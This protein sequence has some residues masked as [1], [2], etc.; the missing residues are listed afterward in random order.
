[1]AAPTMGALVTSTAG[2][3][4]ISTLFPACIAKGDLV[5]RFIAT[6]NTTFMG[7]IGGSAAGH[8]MGHLGKD[9]AAGGDGWFALSVYDCTE[10]CNLVSN[11]RNAGEH[12]AITFR[13][14]GAANDFDGLLECDCTW[15]LTHQYT[16]DSW[17]CDDLGVTC[18]VIDLTSIVHGC[19]SRD[20]LWIIGAAGGYSLNDEWGTD[21]PD[22]L[23]TGYTRNAT[24][25]YNAGGFDKNAFILSKQTTSDTGTEDPDACLIVCS[26]LA[27]GTSAVTFLGAI[28]A[29][30]A[31]L[32]FE[33]CCVADAPSYGTKASGGQ[34]TGTSLALNRPACT[35]DNDLL[36]A[37]IAR[38]ENAG[39]LQ[40]CP[41]GWTLLGAING[42]Q[43]DVDIFWKKASCEPSSWTWTSGT[44]D[45]WDYEVYRFTG[46]CACAAPFIS[47]FTQ[48][49]GAYK[50]TTT[51]VTITCG[52]CCLQNLFLAFNV[53]DNA[54]ICG[55][56]ATPIG[57]TS[58]G[59]FDCCRSSIIMAWKKYVRGTSKPS[60]W[61][62]GNNA[63]TVTFSIGIKEVS[64]PAITSLSP[65]SG[66]SGTGVTIT[67]SGF[68]GANQVRF[69]GKLADFSVTNDTTVEATAPNQNPGKKDVFVRNVNN[70]ENVENANNDF[71]YLGGGGG[72]SPG[73]A[74]PGSGPKGKGKQKGGGGG[75]GGTGGAGG[76]DPL[77]SKVNP[78]FFISCKPGTSETLTANIAFSG[79]NT[80][81]DG[82]FPSC[83]NKSL[84]IIGINTTFKGAT[85]NGVEYYFGTGANLGTN[86]GSE[87]SEIQNPAS[88][89]RLYSRFWP[90]GAGPIGHPGQRFSFK[91]TVDVDEAV[92]AVVYYKEETQAI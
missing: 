77:G 8:H 6:D 86:A 41:S 92:S 49:S 2:S 72:S 71:T 56:V 14:S 1:M 66:V 52:G 62:Q 33:I 84:R 78:D 47:T 20:Y 44:C 27:C 35:A 7:H 58:A 15:P 68:C 39:A 28:R 10:G 63:Q 83:A 34:L 48:C 74:G 40:C 69:G 32:C 64:L 54:A 67:G 19:T 29:V 61:L 79:C 51:A 60:S 31:T 57:F 45:V 23:P 24:I 81:Q 17:D 91:G 59:S 11:G 53:D 3:G 18:G 21:C 25:I 76:G 87:I 4:E 30:D 16:D 55:N 70:L 43:T 37:L 42:T 26:T 13:I 12:A 85:A 75:G 89:R 65:T 82:I 38:C 46:A 80:R 9:Q 5:L 50:K 36:I 22:S 73:G 90:I 88:N